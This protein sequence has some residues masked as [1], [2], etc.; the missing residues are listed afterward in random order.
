[1]FGA[2]RDAAARA[3]DEPA[4]APQ[5]AE[6][7]KLARAA[8]LGVAHNQNGI[9]GGLNPQLK[10]GA[11]VRVVYALNLIHFRLRLLG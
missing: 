9:G 2:E 1:V 11:F 5:D 4:R 10:R 3:T 7:L 8:F 6:V